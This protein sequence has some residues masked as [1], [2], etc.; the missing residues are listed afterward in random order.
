MIYTEFVTKIRTNFNFPLYYI[1][2]RDCCCHNRRAAIIE[3]FRA[4]RSAME[5]IRFFGYPRSTIYDVAAKYTALEQSNEI[6]YASEEESVFGRP[7]VFSTGRCTGSYE[8]FDSKLVLRQRRYVLVQGILASQ[9]PRFK[10][11]GLCS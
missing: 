3:D 9:Q 2:V 1:S 5:I 8:S 11:L 6:Q 7:Y 10:S 4:E